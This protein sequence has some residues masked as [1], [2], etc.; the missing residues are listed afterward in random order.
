MKN[1]KPWTIT[2]KSSGEIEI[3]LYET[4]GAD[5]WSEGTTAKSFAED[6]KT[7]GSVSKI[8][9][10][11][12]SPGGNVFDGI[13]IYNT[14]LSHGA[15]VTAQVDGIAGSIAS[16]ITM[17]ASEISMGDNAMMMIHNP[18]TMIAGDSNKMRKMAETM[19]KVKTSMIAAY[20]RHTT[21]SIEEVGT[22]MDA[23]T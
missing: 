19:D 15:T 12:N 6:L 18:A 14:L 23:E 13:A 21:K 8:H 3:L 4:I 2:A 22:L 5:F 10:R 7:A 11:L 1:H 9:L 17:A 20:R 16:V